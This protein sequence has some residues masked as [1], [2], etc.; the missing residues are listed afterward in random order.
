VVDDYE[1]WRQFVCSTLQINPTYQVISELSDG[2]EAVQRAHELQPDLIVL[3]IGLPILNGIE[4]ARRIRIQASEAKI[5][6]L[7]ENRSL[8][9]AEEALRSGG[10][11][12]VLKS[13][14]AGELLLAI[15][16][17]LQGKCFVSAS[18]V[19]V[20]GD[21]PDPS[22]GY[23][24]FQNNVMAIAPRPG[25]HEVG[26]YSD[27]RR[28]LEH[29]T[30]FIGAALV[31]GNAAIIAATES[32]RDALIPRLQSYGVDVGAAIEQGRYVSLDATEAMAAF[33]CN[34]M[35]DPVR[36]VKLF[37]QLILAAART[38][39]ALN[40][41]VA[42]FGECVNLLLAEGNAEAAVQVEKLGNQLIKA[43]NVDILCAYF[44]LGIVRGMDDHTFQRICAE[45]S[46][47]HDR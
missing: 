28:L 30:Q 23:H 43:H 46:T 42:I 7:S 40:P 17:V 12:Y 39:S 47:A 33:M 5:L 3:D 37:D 26:F 18:L 9:V 35:P 25:R 11:G 2:F 24:P 1:R 10:S 29:L 16:A 19:A 15:E 8:D 34:R 21:R 38:S 20:S 41:R 22:S 4:A 45:H 44:P 32:H 13:E 27:D 14:A 36:F 31:A 6:F